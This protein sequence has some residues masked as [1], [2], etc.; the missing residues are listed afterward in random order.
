MQHI[1]KVPDTV[2]TTPAQRI[3]AFD[4]KLGKIINE[5]KAVLRA[6]RKPKG[7]GLAAP[8]VGIGLRLF[9]TRPKDDDPIR[10][11]INPEIIKRSDEQTDG[12][13]DR[14]RKLEGCLSIDAIWGKVKRAAT[15]SLR[16]QDETGAIHEESFTGFMATIIQHETDHTNGILFTHR[17][18]E[19]KGKLYQTVKD[20]EG[21]EVLEELLLK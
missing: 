9:I 18:L 5:M 13:P 3:T 16:Y 14:D 4:Q 1:V 20:D 19:Q 7:V 21:K 8:Q 15:I 2:L 17:V 11:F 12:V 10:V 6:T